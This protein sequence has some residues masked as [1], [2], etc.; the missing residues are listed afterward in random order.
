MAEF[1][2]TT[3]LIETVH[4]K[5]YF[6][7]GKTSWLHAVDDVNLQIFEGETL[8]VVGESGCGK[9]TLGRTILQL[10]PPTDGKVLFRGEEINAKSAKQMLEMRKQMQIIFQ[11]PYASL[12]PRMTVS[13]HLIY[14]FLW[15]H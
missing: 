9:S 11:D 10:L 1:D 12:N 15:Q 6:K 4:L 2:K 8:G 13:E 3:P 14:L 5:K 7:V